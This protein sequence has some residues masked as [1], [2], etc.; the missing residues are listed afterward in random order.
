MQ[1]HT[2]VEARQT[3]QME[4]LGVRVAMPSLAWR[5]RLLRRVQEVRDE[6]AN[7][8]RCFRGDLTGRL[9]G[10][11]TNNRAQRQGR[12]TV[13]RDR[14]AAGCARCRHGR[15][16]GLYR[17]RRKPLDARLLPEFRSGPAQTEL[18]SSPEQRQMSGLHD[19]RSSLDARGEPFD[20]S[21][22]GGNRSLSTP[23]AERNHLRMNRTV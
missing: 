6:T 22:H 14:A 2:T 12:K 17:L 15:R 10:S 7:R 9:L 8:W 19:A 16:K 11:S 23:N 1:L 4:R 3:P 20:S 5:P 18:R 21:W 13:L